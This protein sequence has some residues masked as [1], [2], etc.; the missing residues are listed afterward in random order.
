M[1]K[2]TEFHSRVAKRVKLKRGTVRVYLANTRGFFPDE[3]KIESGRVQTYYNPARVDEA[4][5]ILEGR[6][7]QKR[8]RKPN[9]KKQ[10]R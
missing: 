2:S 1:I 10:R 9:T 7:I 5:R 6:E 8:G 3:E 4:V